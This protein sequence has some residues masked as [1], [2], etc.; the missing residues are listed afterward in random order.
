M[1]RQRG[2][3]ITILSTGLLLERHAAQIVEFTDEVIVSLDGPREVHDAI[4]R[5]PGAFDRMAAGIQVL[6]GM[7][8][9]YPVAARCTVQAA[10]AGRL[11]DTVAAARELAAAWERSS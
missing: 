10:N 6:R 11:C 9:A 7:A 5:V 3:R 2:I 4:R 8:P 1:L